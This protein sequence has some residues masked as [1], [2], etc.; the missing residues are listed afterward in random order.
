MPWSSLR[1]SPPL[2]EVPH[3][4]VPLRLPRVVKRA[5]WSPRTYTHTP[6]PHFHVVLAVPPAFS[7]KAKPQDTEGQCLLAPPFVP[8][9]DPHARMAV[10]VPGLTHS[11]S[12]AQASRQVFLKRPRGSHSQAQKSLGPCFLVNEVNILAW[13]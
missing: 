10:V 11:S 4:G 12:P 8:F 5:L 3:D 13:H 7:P 6:L 1:S 9:S 2:P